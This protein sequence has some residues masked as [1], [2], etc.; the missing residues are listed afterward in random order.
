[1][2]LTQ[3]DCSRPYNGSTSR[4][5]DTLGFLTARHEV[6]LAYVGIPLGQVGSE[7]PPQ[8][9]S[10]LASAVE[11]T[12]GGFVSKFFNI[13]LF[14]AAQ[15]LVR[16]KRFDL[17]IVEFGEAG[18]YGLALRALHGL[19]FVYM[20]QNVE[21]QLHLQR[22]RPTLLRRAFATFLALIER[23]S[24]R[25]A[26][27]VTTVTAADA[28]VFRKWARSGGQ[29][30]VV[31]VGFRA[32]RFNPANARA[33][34]PPKLVFVGNMDYSP[35]LDAVRFIVDEVMEGVLKRR[36]DAV[37]Q[38]VGTHPPGLEDTAPRAEFTGFVDDLAGHL[39][40]ARLVLVPVMVGGGMRMKTVEA[41][42]CGKMVIASGRGADGI[43][44]RRVRR[45]R[46]VEPEVFGRTIL[47]ELEQGVADDDIDFP[48]LR[49]EFS[50]EA[51]LDR[52]DNELRKIA[53]SRA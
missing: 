42:A 21:C 13:R 11:A 38:F 50:T 12:R 6:H 4:I 34:D 3:V 52:F 5:H 22:A 18:V 44:L 39:K 36:P 2:Y 51:T 7:V 10:G 32:S 43:D 33:E 9:P 53:A 27:L 15:R 1:M 14:R 26:E 41:L 17:A 48:Y 20:S 47:E 23:L 37:F 30:Q 19:P 31:P 45:I 49:A 40:Q 25:Y 16:S 29:V 24:A 46:L 28:A 35:N 8:L